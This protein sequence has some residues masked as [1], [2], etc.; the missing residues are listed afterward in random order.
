M[1]SGPRLGGNLSVCG[2]WPSREGGGWSQARAEAAATDGLPGSPGPRAAP[3]GSES[4]VSGGRQALTTAVSKPVTYYCKTLRDGAPVTV[5]AQNY[6]TSREHSQA[7]PAGC[8]LV[9]LDWDQLCG[10]TCPHHPLCVVSVAPMA[11]LPVVTLQTLVW[12][13]LFCASDQVQDRA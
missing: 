1:S 13:G 8:S 7:E 6:D 5:V 11:G 12:F 4:L 9:F 10:T 2:Y 3:F